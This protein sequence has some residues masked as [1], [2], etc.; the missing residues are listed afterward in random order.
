[1]EALSGRVLQCA[2]GAQQ[3]QDMRRRVDID[4]IDSCNE[5]TLG[6]GATLCATL[7][8]WALFLPFFD[9]AGIAWVK[10][11]EGVRVMP[12]GPPITLSEFR[13]RMRTAN[14]TS[15]AETF[16]LV[17]EDRDGSAD[18]RE[19]LRG[20][21]QFRPPLD[22]TEA[23]YAFRGFDRN[24][25]KHLEPAELEDA[26]QY[27]DFFATS[28]TTTATLDGAAFDNDSAGLAPVAAGTNTTTAEA[29]V[30][31]AGTTTSDVDVQST[32]TITTG[33]GGATS[34]TTETATGTSTAAPRKTTTRGA[35]SNE[36]EAPA[37]EGPAAAAGAAAGPAE[38]SMEDFRKRKPK[39]EHVA[40]FVTQVSNVD[41]AKM[42]DDERKDIQMILAMDL[43]DA[44]GI[45]PSRVRDME[46]RPESVT[47]SPGS[48]PGTL[49][50]KAQLHVPGDKR[51]EDII[52]VVTSESSR[53]FIGED[54]SNLP[55]LHDAMRGPIR[56]SHVQMSARKQNSDAF[57]LIDA[58]H[59]GAL[60]FNEF[61]QY[62]KTFD[63]PLTI[64][65]TRNA[66]NKLDA[67]SDNK[68]SVLEMEGNPTPVDV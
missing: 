6:L 9:I 34:T 59:D 68:L 53:Q 50:V 38:I 37:T 2:P 48:T 35:A 52:E 47:L 51:T 29:L 19:F 40:A 25:D 42:S 54:L 27:S 11:W 46:G 45:H 1:M 32:A 26:L 31:D 43:A 5:T 36:T 41:M 13:G 3:L 20:T 7:G 4:N 58:D 56:A 67:N 14:C 61:S 39:P 63:P 60:A 21:R 17:D 23:E 33:D 49:V 65:Q 30:P 18:F 10:A 55:G 22:V 44:A 28:T 8:I 12:E 64:A 66:F 24:N 15:M 57:I 62:T 16:A